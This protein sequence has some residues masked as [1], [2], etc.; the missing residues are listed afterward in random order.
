MCSKQES[1]YVMKVAG[2]SED[3]ESLRNKFVGKVLKCGSLPTRMLQNEPSGATYIR[4]LHTRVCGFGS[5]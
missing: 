1:S 4:D 5:L 2:T 3:V